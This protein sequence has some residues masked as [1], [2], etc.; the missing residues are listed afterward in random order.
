MKRYGVIVMDKNTGKR[1]SGVKVELTDFA[2]H[3]DG[4][5][6]YESGITDNYGLVWL[7]LTNNLRRK[8]ID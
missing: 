4:S 2:M 1:I 7:D 8:Q 5:P 6:V 3:K